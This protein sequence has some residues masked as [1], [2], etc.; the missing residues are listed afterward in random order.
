MHAKYDVLSNISADNPFKTPLIAWVD[1]GYYREMTSCSGAGQFELMPPPDFDGSSVAFT[2]VGPDDVLTRDVSDI[3]RNNLVWV[4]GGMLIAQPGVILQFATDYK[5]FV[6]RLLKLGLSNTDQQMIAAMY[7]QTMKSERRVQ[8]QTYKCGQ[9]EW[10]CLGYTARD[11]GLR[12]QRRQGQT[13]Y[14][15]RHFSM[16]K[17]LS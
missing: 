7:S 8:L 12:I 2:R 3:V 11:E 13:M 15:S 9:D 5:S 1:I 17:T 10:F 4:G 14:P 6:R 16:L